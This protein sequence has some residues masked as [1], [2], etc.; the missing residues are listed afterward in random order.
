MNDGFQKEDLVHEIETFLDSDDIRLPIT[1][2]KEIFP[3]KSDIFIVGGALRNVIINY[4]HKAAPKTIDIDIF[5][6]N[7]S[8]KYPLEVLFKNLR[9]VK[10]DLG[11]IRWYPE[12]SEF[13][14]DLCL[15][16]KFLPIRKYGLE[17]T[18][19]NLLESLDFN[20]NA[21]IYQVGCHAFHEKKCI[22]GIRSRIMHFNTRLFGDKII[23]IYRIL[24]ISHKIDF[25]ISEAIYNYL[26]YAVDLSTLTE[27]KSVL[28]S[29]FGMPKA[30]LILRWY[31]HMAGFGDYSQYFREESKRIL[32]V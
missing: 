28:A 16:P 6:G 11:G 24:V 14:F 20:V 9:Y 1:L 4:F 7:I 21:V 13:S 31:D 19:N 25:L 32:M 17:P 23:L 15:V 27:A 26:K 12:R 8:E 22:E 3:K 2:L 5:I 29:K 18:L 10:T 30:D